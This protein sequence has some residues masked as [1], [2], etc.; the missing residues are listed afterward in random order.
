MSILFVIHNIIIICLKEGWG[1]GGKW[2]NK[3]TRVLVTLHSTMHS[4]Y[5]ATT[6]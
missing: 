5:F 2:S 1:G 3:E 6:P 4:L